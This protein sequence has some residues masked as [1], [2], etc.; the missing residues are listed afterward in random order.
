MQAKSNATSDMA[1]ALTRA[2][3]TPRH[4]NPSLG[5]APKFIVRS[6]QRM[7]S[8]SSLNRLFLPK[9]LSPNVLMMKPPKI[10]SPEMVA[11]GRAR[12]KS[13]TSLYND[14]CALT[15]CNTKHTL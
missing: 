12:R 4:R 3:A 9:P 2:I 15:S 11:V 1:P 5:L 14:S 10:D 13:G 8:M 6:R 7:L